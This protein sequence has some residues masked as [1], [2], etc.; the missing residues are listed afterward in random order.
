ML[1]FASA[2]RSEPSGGPAATEAVPRLPKTRASMKVEVAGERGAHLGHYGL[3]AIGL[4]LGLGA[5]VLAL[6]DP[7]TALVLSGRAA[8][9]EALLVPLALLGLCAI[10]GALGVVAVVYRGSL[11]LM[12]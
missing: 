5:I 3:L 4:S 8:A 9:T 7:A 11:A 12:R 6:A 2:S 1:P 10:L